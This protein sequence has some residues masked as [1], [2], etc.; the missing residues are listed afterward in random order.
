MGEI[1]LITYK[2][3]NFKFISSDLNKNSPQRVPAQYLRRLFQCRPGRTVWRPAAVWL[4]TSP[5]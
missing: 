1:F 3:I 4:T 5:A 2:G